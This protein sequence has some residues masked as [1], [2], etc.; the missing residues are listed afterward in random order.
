M[1]NTTLISSSH[2]PYCSSQWAHVS[3]KRLLVFFVLAV[4]SAALPVYSSDDQAGSTKNKKNDAKM[5]DDYINAKGYTSVI[6]F[7]SMNIKQFWS[8]KTVLSKDGNIIIDLPNN[9]ESVRESISQRIQLANVN[10]TQN[11]KVDVVT[12]MSGVRF[13]VLDSQNKVLTTSASEEDFLSYHILSSEF[14]LDKIPDFSFM[15]KFAYDSSD[16]ISIKK[17]V[18]SFSRNSQSKYLASPGIL[19]IDKDSVTLSNGA[20]FVGDSFTVTG[21]NSQI[22]SDKRILSSNNTFTTS[23]KVKNIG[24]GNIRL[25]VGFMTCSNR[26]VK[27][28]SRHFP[29]KE[30]SKVLKVVSAEKG[31]NKMIVDSY[32]EWI[33][34]CFIAMDAKEDLSDIPNTSLVEGRLVEM[35]ELENC[36]GEITLNKPL[37]NA[38]IAGT[39]VRIQGKG[40]DYL[41][42]NFKVLKPG[43]EEVITSSIRKDDNCI[44]YSSEAFPRGTYYVVPLILSYVTGSAESNTVQIS[45]YT[46]SY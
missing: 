4:S 45:D 43:E 46:I 8:D 19:K 9:Q 25:Y 12:E 33:K 24:N 36:Q 37:K 40:G 15:L 31:S 17:I 1:S 35:K 2:A 23:V 5:L 10:E 34:N 14:Q 16:S 28:D 32:Q 20:V 42:T 11:C 22:I 38:I 39:N 6:T 30:N 13:A 29:Y 27:L 21:K 18:L 44:K 41:Y 3:I 26:G 7:D